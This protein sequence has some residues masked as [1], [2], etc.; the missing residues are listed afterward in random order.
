MFKENR[1]YYYICVFFLCCVAGWIFEVLFRSGKAG[2]L[3]VPGFLYGC[4]LPIYGFGALML[5]FVFSGNKLFVGNVFVISFVLLTAVEYITHFFFDK[6]L[7]VQLWSY[8]AHFCN[9]N[10]RISLKQ[11]IMLGVGG[12]AFVY[13]I[14]PFLNYILC[15]ISEKK[16]QVF[17]CFVILTM[18]IDAVFSVF[19]VIKK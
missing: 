4:Y 16:K 8:S 14:Y 3:S 5:I 11:S 18:T 9:I 7:D 2:C 15:R 19:R 1:L 6:I 13:V 12:T 17:A 10:G